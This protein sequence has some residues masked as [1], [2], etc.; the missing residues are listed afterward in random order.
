MYYPFSD[1]YFSTW[2][3]RE[4][5]KQKKKQNNCSYILLT[6]DQISQVSYFLPNLSHF[7]VL[8]TLHAGVATE[9]NSFIHSFI[10]PGWSPSKLSSGK[11]HSTQCTSS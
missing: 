3:G 5:K 8:F 7:Q 9:H 6:P 10:H 4:A 2:A 11:G 1:H